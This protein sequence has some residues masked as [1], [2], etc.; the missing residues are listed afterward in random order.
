MKEYNQLLMNKKELK[1]TLQISTHQSVDEKKR[2][3]Q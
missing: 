1:K 2:I 3:S